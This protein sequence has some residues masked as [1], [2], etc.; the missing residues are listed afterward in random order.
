[1]IFRWVDL[2]KM[3]DLPF[4]LTAGGPGNATETANIFIMRMGFD[5][6]R[7]GY[8]SALSVTFVVGFLL[9]LGV[10]YGARRGYVRASLRRV[11]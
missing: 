3:F 8:A 6:L 5:S 9:T 11:S 10:I 7:M 1:M 2:M 4:I